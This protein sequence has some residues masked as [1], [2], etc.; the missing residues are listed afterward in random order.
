MKGISVSSCFDY[1]IDFKNQLGL[2]HNAGFSHFSIGSNYSHSGILKP[3]NYEE[4]KTLVNDNELLI[5]T[6]HGYAM[7]KTDT[8]I[9]NEKIAK[10]ANFL[11]VPVIVVHCSSFAINHTTL[12]ERKRDIVRK[13]PIFESIAKTYGVT[14]AFENVLPGVATDLTEFTV[15]NSNPAYFGF[16]Y[17]SSH[18]QIDGPRSFDLLKRNLNRLEAV[19]ISDRICEFVDHVTPGEGFIDFNQ[20]AEIF[21]SA[22]LSFPL[23][24]EVNTEHS[25]YKRA[26]EFL[27]ATY[28]EALKL[29][30]KINNNCNDENFCKNIDKE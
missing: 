16:C 23:L 28:K 24:M 25:K 22:N 29:Y 12:D 11:S 26:D 5:D 30:N 19:H 17:D 21:G 14:F 10:A 18:D 1:S 27:S 7:D 2:I 8:I 20:I 13:L 9:I 3:G 6:I 15:N 4:I